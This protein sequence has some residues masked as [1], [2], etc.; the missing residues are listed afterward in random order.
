MATNADALTPDYGDKIPAEVRGKLHAVAGAIMAL[1]GVYG[2]INESQIAAIGFALVALLDLILVL[3]YTTDLWRKAL[4]PLL[5]A[6][7][8]VL[9]VFAIMSQA[10]VGAILGVALAVLGSQT[11]S[12]YTPT[13]QKIKQ[14]PEGAAAA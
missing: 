12:T 13:V 2:W 11:A 7:G 8:G 9:V 6:S 14:F 5:Y 1:V 10:E 4:Y 3:Y